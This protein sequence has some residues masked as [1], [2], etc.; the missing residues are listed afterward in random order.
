MRNITSTTIDSSGA[1]DPP[2]KKNTL[3]RGSGIVADAVDTILQEKQMKGKKAAK[4]KSVNEIDELSDAMFK[5][6]SE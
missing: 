4:V 5:L 2:D 1:Y 3:R 6:F